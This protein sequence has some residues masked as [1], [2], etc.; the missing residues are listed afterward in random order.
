MKI[1]RNSLSKEERI[2]S[3]IEIDRLFTEGNSFI[4]YPLRVIYFEKVSLEKRKA[5]VSIMASV[6]KRKFKR[7]VKRNRLKRLIKESY[8]LNKFAFIA[9][10]TSQSKHISLA[11]LYLPH[12]EKKFPEIEMAMKQA[13]RT[14]SSK[15]LT[16]KSL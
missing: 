6:P 2:S 15:I 13:L 5:N 8:R 11:F 1:K 3:K 12:E 7:A 10:I 9:K 4:I 14:L 16:Q